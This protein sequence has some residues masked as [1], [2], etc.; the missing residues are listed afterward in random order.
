MLLYR[1][2][3]PLMK[4]KE[5]IKFELITLSASNATVEYVNWFR[6][7]EVSRNI[8]W[9]PPCSIDEAI[10]RLTEYIISSESNP[11]IEL[12]GIILDGKHV[13]NVRFANIT[14]DSDVCTVGILIGEASARGIGLAP[15]ALT[16]ACHYINQIH[17]IRVFEL[18]VYSWNIGAIR[19]YSKAG[20]NII[21][22]GKKVEQHPDG[23]IMSFMI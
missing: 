20:F 16:Q 13:G 8:L 22:R 21:E 11:E 18:R 15:L 6:D 12:L 14:K 19:A 2:E 10:Q 4:Q 3:V 1:K 5:G 17:K 9:R 23:T 7:P